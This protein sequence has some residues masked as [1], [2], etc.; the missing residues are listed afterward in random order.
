MVPSPFLSV[1]ACLNPPVVWRVWEEVNESLTAAVGPSSS[2]PDHLFHFT[3][4]SYNILA[5]DLLEANQQL[6][7]HCPLEALDWSNRYNLLLQEILQWM[8]DVRVTD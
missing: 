3:V 6:Y 8:P 7:S 1:P 5:Q 2:N 4:M